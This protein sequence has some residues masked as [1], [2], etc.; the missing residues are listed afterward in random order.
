[1]VH[2]NQDIPMDIKQ[3]ERKDENEQTVE[4]ICLQS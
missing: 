4:K 3:T 2:Y 1:M